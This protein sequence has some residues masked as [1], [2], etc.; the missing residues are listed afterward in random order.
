MSDH[1][2][3]KLRQLT[4]ALLVLRQ[5]DLLWI[6]QVDNNELLGIRLLLQE[7]QMSLHN[8]V[9]QQ[10]SDHGPKEHANDNENDNND[11]NN[12]DENHQTILAAVLRIAT[13]AHSGA[14]ARATVMCTTPTRATGGMMVAVAIVRGHDPPQ[15]KDISWTPV[16]VRGVI[17]V[18]IVVARPTAHP[19]AVVATIVVMA[20]IMLASIVPTAA[21]DAR[22]KHAENEKEHDKSPE[23]DSALPEVVA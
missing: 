9:H 1:N 16:R 19:P 23:P 17:V 3:D 6:V 2:L 5:A 8:F 15:E 22:A 4:F 21:E 14:A 13:T 20:I 10:E 12:D 7:L 18:A 11:D